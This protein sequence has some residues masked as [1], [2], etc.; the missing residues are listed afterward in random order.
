MN[1]LKFYKIASISLLLLNLILVSAFLITK[2]K[3]RPGFGGGGNAQE[4][5]KLDDAQHELFLGNVQSHH[6]EMEAIKNKKIELLKPYL[7]GVG[8]NDQSQNSDEV[9]QKIKELEGQKLV[10]TYNHL[11]DVKNMMKEDQLPLFNAFL[12]ERLEDMTG[13]DFERRP[14][15][16]K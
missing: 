12:N 3:G 11:L 8:E 13:K 9:V 2:P 1:K 5:L 6:K 10:A 15:P 16:N 14:R 4:L 7:K